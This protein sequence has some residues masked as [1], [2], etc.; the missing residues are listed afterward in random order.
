MNL[1]QK[2]KELEEK[3][4]V[5]ESSPYKDAYLGLHM[6]IQRWSLELKDKKFEISSTTDD[7]MKSFE[8]AHKTATSMDILFK[9]LDFLRTK[10]TP[11]QEAEVRKE[12]T[13]IFEKAL[14]DNGRLDENS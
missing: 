9:Q 7:D 3:L 1:E 14:Q 6:T 2:V 11:E 13:S 12:A 4:A 8:K 10:I 5:Y